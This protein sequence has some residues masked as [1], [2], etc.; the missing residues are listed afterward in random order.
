MNHTRSTDALEIRNTTIPYG[1][2][3]A[4]ERQRKRLTYAHAKTVYY[5]VEPDY[6]DRSVGVFGDGGNGSYEWFIWD[7]ETHTLRTSDCG[8][9]CIGVAL[10]CGLVES[11]ARH[12]RG[13]HD[14]VLA[15][16]RDAAALEAH[17]DRELLER[18]RVAINHVFG[19]MGSGSTIWGN[20]QWDKG[21][22]AGVLAAL[23]AFD[24]E[25][26]RLA[27]PRQ[28]AQEEK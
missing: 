17:D 23:T 12:S 6:R 11:G 3:E 1:L 20:T 26:Q 25:R 7:W 28:T 21:Y 24:T 16:I 13:D 5:C 19:G 22:S 15:W 14:V 8:F 10:C 9:G 2:L 18:L 27:A 4:L